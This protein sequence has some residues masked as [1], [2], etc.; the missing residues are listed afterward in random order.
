M[1]TIS[2]PTPGPWHVI[3]YNA[4]AKSV[5][6]SGGAQTT[7]CDLNPAAYFEG[8]ELEANARLIAAA[9]ELLTALKWCLL[10]LEGESGGCVSHWEQFPE[11]EAACAAVAKTEGR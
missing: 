5:G 10:Q 9:P 3:N 2:K 11:Y 6:Q 4:G 1:D 7:V 8:D